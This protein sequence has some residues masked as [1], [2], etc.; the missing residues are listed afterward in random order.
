MSERFCKFCGHTVV[1]PCMDETDLLIYRVTV[2]RC[3]EAAWARD[4]EVFHE[5]DRPE[6]PQE[7]TR[8]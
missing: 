5:G 8:E 1:D 2:E 4:A 6:C 3:N 7:T